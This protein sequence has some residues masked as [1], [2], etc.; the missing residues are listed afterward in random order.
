VE[1]LKET[2]GLEAVRVAGG[3]LDREITQA[4][5]CAGAGRSFLSAAAARGVEL[6]V[7]GEV[8][9]HDAVD[10]PSEMT[11]VCLGHGASERPAMAKLRENLA[12][13]TEAVGFQLAAAPAEPFRLG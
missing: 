8:G 5:C 13:R 9:H 7:T 4:A 10:A 1:G 2:L 12:E 3:E 11:I 6:F